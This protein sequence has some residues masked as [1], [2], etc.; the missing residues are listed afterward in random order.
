MR[1]NIK[2]F[3]IIVL[4]LLLVLSCLV[5]Y[6]KFLPL[7]EEFNKHIDIVY[8]INLDK[9]PDRN[10]EFLYEAE[11]AG[12]P[13]EKIV[14]IQAVYEENRGALG[15]SKSHIQ[16]LR[17]FIDSGLD[18][19]IIF[20]D[21]FEFIDPS[22][23]LGKIQSVVIDREIPYDVI[24]LSGN[25]FG[26]APSNHDGLYKVSDSQTTS[27]YMVSKEFAPILLANYI[28]GCDLLEKSYN[29][30]EYNGQYAIDQYWKTL[31]PTHKWYIFEPRLG[32]QRASY[33]DIQGGITDYNV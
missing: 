27:G 7:K 28:E 2:Y 32:K 16:T 31:Q 25:V 29:G 1:I 8:Y 10:A 19:C 3:A 20:E 33:S 11:K 15:C 14:R 17:Q 23:A 26:S 6:I 24:M 9:R 18:N 12:I 22:T 4:L 30:R 21:D 5:Y 13:R